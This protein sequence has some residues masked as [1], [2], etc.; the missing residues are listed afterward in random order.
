MQR[1]YE[2]KG[3][4]P[5]KVK[6]RGQWRTFHR[7]SSDSELAEQLTKRY[8][9]GTL[10]NDQWLLAVEQPYEPVTLSEFM[11]ETVDLEDDVDKGA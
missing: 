11:P 5:R 2:T 7:I 4:Q 1:M 9:P 3:P 6:V 8:G 10:V